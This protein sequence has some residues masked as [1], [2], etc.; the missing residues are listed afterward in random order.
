[1]IRAIWYW[2]LLEMY[3][4]WKKRYLKRTASLDAVLLTS[5]RQKGQAKQIFIAYLGSIRENRLHF[6]PCRISFWEKV[7][8]IMDGLLLKTA[9]KES[10]KQ[11]LSGKVPRP[12][13]E[14]IE[15]HEN[16]IAQYRLQRQRKES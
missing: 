5:V 8:F 9:D 14:E 13:T 2:G 4:R 7:D 3:V 16:K 12:S 1:M 15:A 10:I 6:I 11:T